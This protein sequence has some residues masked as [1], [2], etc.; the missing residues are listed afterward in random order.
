MMT[1]DPSHNHRQLRFIPYLRLTHKTGTVPPAD[2]ILHWF[3]LDGYFLRQVSSQPSYFI[4]ST[5][6]SSSKLPVSQLQLISHDQLLSD[7]Y[8]M[9]S[10]LVT[11]FRISVA[12]AKMVAWVA[13]ALNLGLTTAENYET[14]TTS[15]G[16]GT[17]VFFSPLDQEMKGQNDVSYK[18]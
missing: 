13:G 9:C 18:L 4:T 3:N 5:A 11:I 7:V 8:C 12:A 2:V 14:T 15:S 16:V 10:W 6:N 1:P 17:G